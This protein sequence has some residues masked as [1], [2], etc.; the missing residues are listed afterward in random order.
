MTVFNVSLVTNVSAVLGIQSPKD[1]NGKL[2]EFKIY[3]NAS[4]YED[5][6]GEQE[7]LYGPG[8][9]FNEITSQGNWFQ[10]VN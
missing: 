7:Q 8:D 3:Y 9:A 2:R 6:L 4:S 10:L 5:Q 1:W